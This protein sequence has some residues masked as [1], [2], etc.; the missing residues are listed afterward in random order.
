MLLSAEKLSKSYGA[1]AVLDGVSFTINAGERIGVVGANG[2]GKSTLLRLL[3]GKEQPDSGAVMCAPDV[4]VGYLRQ[5]VPDISG[6]TVDALI[7]A[8]VAHL[9][10]LAGRMRALEAEMGAAPKDTLGALLDEYGAI[11][12]RF[13]DA[14]G[15]ET[16]HHIERVLAGLGVA[17]I[18]RERQIATLSGGEKARVALAALLLQTP[19]L[20]LLDEPTNH[21]DL[22]I[23]DWLEDYLARYSGAILA[24]SHDRHFLNRAVNRI[25]A[26]DDVTHQITR[27]Q[28][29]YDAYAAARV[30]ERAR[31]EDEYTRQQEEI[32]ALRTRMREA[33]RPVGHKR[34]P[35]D[36]DKMAYNFFGGRAQEA[37]ARNIRSAEERLRRIE[38]DLIPKPPKP[39]RFNPRFAATSLRSREVV[40]L[41]GARKAFGDRVVLRG[42][43]AVVRP[44]ARIILVGPNGAGKTTLLRLIAGLE[45][46]DAGEAR[47]APS[48]EA[49]YLPQEPALPNREGTVFEAYR[50]G[51][52][53]PESSFIA[54]LIG[55]GF[56]RLEDMTKTIGQI[57]AGQRRKLEIARLIAAR[58]NLLLLDEPTNYV[59]LDVLEAFESAILSFPGPVIAVSHDRRFIERF[60]GEVWELAGGVITAHAAGSAIALGSTWDAP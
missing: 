42:V 40:T 3:T 48:V 10:R 28:G 23:L 53:G 1:L 44:D 18:P 32:Q 59:S 14:G 27:Y 51:L 47:R 2:A 20:L 39:M 56:F 24:V 52:A 16:D 6:Q 37:V 5:A 17:Q 46:P 55:H 30:A 60:G 15:Y 25:F 9:H 34:P 50:D 22:A 35:S 58:P 8:A 33:A 4:E 57:S 21:L 19:D 11:S 29:G 13:Q 36:R 45:A 26:L 12:T 7:Q 41:N 49:G 38:A 31:W 54:G 43:H